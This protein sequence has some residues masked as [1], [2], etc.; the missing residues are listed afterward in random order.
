MSGV[1]VMSINLAKSYDLVDSMIKR[2]GTQGNSGLSNP[3][4][5]AQQGLDLRND[6]LANLGTKLAFYTQSTIR[7]ESNSPA[8]LAVSRAAGSTF[9]VELRDPDRVARAIDPLMRSFGPFL[10]QRL[11]FGPRDR[12]WK[13][14]ASL[15]FHRTSG[16]PRPQ[17]VI[18]W[19]PSSL[20]PPYSSL[21]RPTLAVGDKA[22]VFA[23][24]KEAAEGTLADDKAWQ[25]MEAF[26]PIIRTLPGEMIYLRLADP[27]PAIPVLVASLPVLIRQINGEISLEARRKGRIAKDV[28]VR[29]DP[30]MVP[31]VNDVSSR[32]FPSV[33]TVTVDAGGAVLSHR[34]PVPTIS[35]PAV[36]A[37]AVSGFLPKIRASMDATR[38]AQCINNLKQIALAMH[39]YVSANNK[40]PRSA[41]L[42]ET[43]KPLLSWRVA[44][45]PYLEQQDL[46]NKFNLD[47]PWDSPQ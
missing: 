33:T 34:E 36:I 15:N 47:E 30:E 42:S 11:R 3:V 43:G 13:F 37:V 12:Q 22:L 20:A 32:L 28:Y 35:S 21:L 23:A 6:L 46:Y 38:R 1:T 19:P 10:R 45:L 29:L 17:F 18:D 41:S 16:P 7:G 26:V 31:T 2:S 24:S 14:A 40:F 39:N 9:S 27:R 44:I 5:M 4:I 8:E 25:P